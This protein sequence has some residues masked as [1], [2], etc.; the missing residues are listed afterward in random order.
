[1]KPDQFFARIRD[2]WRPFARRE[3]E[4]R[5]SRTIPDDN[6]FF[7]SNASGLYRDRYDYNREKV[8]AETL[9]AWRVNP[10]ARSIVRTITA[11]VVGRGVTISCEEAATEAFLRDWWQHPLN[12]IDRQLKRWKDEDTRTGNLFFLFSVEPLSG[13]T[14]VRAVPA[15]LIDEIQSAGNDVEQEKYFVRKELGAP[16]WPAFDTHEDQSEFMVHYASNQ[17]VG[18]PWGEPDLAPLLPW[19]GRLSSLLED[20]ARLNRF[21]NAF[22]YVVTGKFPNV[23]AKRTR[24]AEINANPPQPGSVLV[25]DESET[26]NTLNPELDSFDA[27]A[28]I[29]AIKKYVAAG[30]NFP[31][32]WLAEPESSTRTTA[33]AAGTPTFRN[34]EEIQTDFFRM[35]EDLARTAVQVRGRTDPSVNPRAPIHVEGP[36]ITERDNSLLALAVNRIYPAL[37]DLLDRKLIDEPELL[38]LVYRMAAEGA[39][40]GRPN[41][42]GDGNASRRPARPSGPVSEPDPGE[43]E[44]T[45]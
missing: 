22:M 42:M 5:L 18:V 38:R 30:V 17:P 29:L 43:K 6:I 23:D 3:A 16:P 35:L 33:E 1:M 15:D 7:G 12:R 25:V 28:D 13:M 19:I 39:P 27:N 41:D 36:D 45:E 20:R 4:R 21:R 31:L 9:R 34:L 32:H 11:F 2:R 40:D 10:V 37:A 24:Q 14:Y 8:L 26:W 44:E